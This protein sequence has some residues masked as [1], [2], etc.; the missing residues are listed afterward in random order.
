MRI[1]FF[2]L[3]Q[4]ILKMNASKMINKKTAALII[5][6]LICTSIRAQNDDS[7]RWI[8]QSDSLYAI[9]VDLYNAKEF[10][11]AIPFFEKCVGIDTTVYAKGH[12]RRNY[13]NNWLASC[14]YKLKDTVKAK[15]LYKDY[16]F[17]APTD[18]RLTVMCD[19]L[20]QIKQN[21]NDANDYEKVLQYSI[22]IMDSSKN[23]VGDS[24]LYFAERIE[25]VGLAYYNL[26]NYSKVLEYFSV[27]MNLKKEI[28]GENH[29]D[30]AVILNNT[31]NIYSILDNY[32][33]ALIL[34]KKSNDIIKNTLGELHPNYAESLSNIGLVY[35]KL[36]NYDQALKY[37]TEALNIRKEVLGEKHPDYASSLN[38]IGSVYYNLGDYD[39]ALKYYNASL[40]VKEE[41]L[42]SNHPDCIPTLN[43]IGH[44]YLYRGD[45]LI[46]LKYYNRAFDINKMIYGEEHP[47]FA[48]SL[49]NIASVYTEM[50]DYNTALKY[51]NKALLINKNVFG[52]E[53]LNYAINLNDIANLY[54]YCGNYDNALKYNLQS[55]NILKNI[56]GE[57]HPYYASFLNSLGIIYSEIYDYDKALEC[58]FKVTDI[59]KKNFGDKNP[60]YAISLNNIGYIYKKMHNSHEALNYFRQAKDIFKECFGENHPNYA[61]SLNN[62]G[63]VYSDLGDDE[64][65]LKYFFQS[66]N[67]KDKILGKDHFDYALSLYNI[68]L[69]YSNMK[70]YEKSLEYYLAS[71]NTYKRTIGENHPYYANCL[72]NISETYYHMKQY[73]QIS[74]YAT[75]AMSIYKK[76]LINNFSF[77]TTEGREH[78]WNEDNNNKIFFS[79]L[80]KWAFTALNDSSLNS[81]AYDAELITKGLLLTSEIEFTKIIKESGDSTLLQDFEEMRLLRLQLDKQYEKTIAER[82]LNCDSLENI[83]DNLEKKLVAN[84]KAYG[85]FTRSIALEWQDVQKNLNETDIAIEFTNFEIK[86]D[87]S[88]Y[89]AL[90]LR[91]GWDAP[92]IIPLTSADKLLNLKI[93][94]SKNITL[95]TALN[96]TQSSSKH[97]LHKNSIYRSQDLADLIWKPLEK[98]LVGVKD[99]YFAPCGILH[100]I[101]I[102]YLSINDSVRMYDKYSIHRVSSTRQLAIENINTHFKSIVLFGGIPYDSLQMLNQSNL[103][104]LRGTEDESNELEWNYLQGSQTEIEGIYNC[105]QKNN[106]EISIKEGYLAT[107]EAFKNL[108]GTKKDIIH[109][110]TH[111][112][113]FTENKAKKYYYFARNPFIMLENAL[114]RS[115]MLFANANYAWSSDTN[116]YEEE[117]DGTLTGSEICKIDLRGTQLVVLSACQT[118]LGEISNEG[119][120]GLQRAFK[121]AGVKTII[122]SFWEVSDAATQILMNQF[123]SNIVKGMSK[124]EAFTV[125]QNTLKNTSGFNDPYYW[126]AFVMLDGE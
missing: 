70:D 82:T 112:F 106:M 32:E 76:D 100:Q 13:S 30:Y 67:I 118:G 110:A 103:L 79:E 36:G 87:S 104:A 90:V 59:I 11:E 73:V 61:T 39:N 3:Q 5:S 113:F 123:Y 115:G 68:G 31:G 72:N 18:R 42:G 6:L 99:I 47:N 8:S 105:L 51:Y 66:L 93:G 86:K 52:E 10:T 71:E 62:I 12:N 124:Q 88:F 91:K 45:Y 109:I 33:E 43:N 84:C 54:C 20:R 81:I 116:L 121:K 92:K 22:I 102:E 95:R 108:D 46:A 94:F 26:G 25:D 15:K 57:E 64:T 24:C 29:P 48:S 96:S 23:A 14:Y 35:G 75:R 56:I 17:V 117:N 28:L 101:G 58:Y 19:S 85:D 65:A 97:T 9:G 119:V 1:T 89:V 50:A 80:G 38:N 120:F 63:S 34:F 125:A 37:Q 44:I 98:E 4:K 27:S 40:R 16:Y 122:M 111:G 2:I 69:I 53:H 41:I 49:S 114:N 126:A 78:F 77:L 83:A 55:I 107:E 74:H 7:L 60:N 21:R